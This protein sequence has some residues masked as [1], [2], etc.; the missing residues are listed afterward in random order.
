MIP[1]KLSFEEANA[2]KK[3]P[4]NFEAHRRTTDRVNLIIDAISPGEALKQGSFALGVGLGTTAAISGISGTF[5]RG[6]F[7]LTING[8]GLAAA[9]ATITLNF[10]TG[11]FEATPFATVVKNG[12]TGALSFTWVES[13]TKLVITLGGL[14]VAGTTYILQYAVRD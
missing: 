11:M 6:R 9:T 3:S 12:G 7:T 4:E 13:K 10:P 2:L 14:P 5:K 8:A 1:R